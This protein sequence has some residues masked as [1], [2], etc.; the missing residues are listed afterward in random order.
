MNLHYTGHFKRQLRQKIKKNPSLKKRIITKL[1]LLL[2]NP[3]HPSLRLHKLK[4]KRINQYSIWVEPNLRITFIK[5][6]QAYILTG[7]L[8]HDQY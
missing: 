7:I 6:K 2:K 5:E 4:G 8:T 1:N 3:S